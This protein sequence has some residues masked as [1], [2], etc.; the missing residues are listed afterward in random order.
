MNLE[1]GEVPHT[2]S[3]VGELPKE[4]EVGRNREVREWEG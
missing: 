4:R 2:V 3:G 1:D